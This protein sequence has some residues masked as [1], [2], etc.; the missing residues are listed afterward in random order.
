MFNTDLTVGFGV[1]VAAQEVKK[2]ILR[3]IS[4]PSVA[5]GDLRPGFMNALPHG[6]GSEMWTVGQGRITASVYG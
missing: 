3:M 5:L 2:L 1:R 6:R 4:R